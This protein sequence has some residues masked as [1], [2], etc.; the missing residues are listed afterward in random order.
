MLPACTRG[1]VFCSDGVTSMIRRLC[2][3]LM[4]VMAASAEPIAQENAA[5]P[6]DYGYR[7]QEYHHKGIIEELRRKTGQLCCDGMGECRA[8]YANMQE[9]TVLLD[10]NW[11][12]IGYASI[13]RDI[14]LPDQFA[15]VCAGRSPRLFACPNVYCVAVPPGT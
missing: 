5:R 12:P 6:G 1:Q 11:C 2:I 8:T 13:R 9:H 14:A 3:C 4:L 15:L 7:H 10:G